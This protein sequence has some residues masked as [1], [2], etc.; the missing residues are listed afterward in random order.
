MGTAGK[1]GKGLLTDLLRAVLRAS[2][3]EL[4]KRAGKI[5]TEQEKRKSVQIGEIKASAE[6]ISKEYD[7]NIIDSNLH[8]AGSYL[9]AIIPVAAG[10]FIA[11]VTLPVLAGAGTFAFVGTGASTTVYMIS[12]GA[13]I[14]GGTYKVVD[15]IMKVDSD[16]NS[17]KDNSHSNSSKGAEENSDE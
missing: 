6:L 2:G 15:N 9:K 16:I 12:N 1:I 14:A 8:N 3:T 13:V 4:G 5:G 7:W 10:T 11:Y 17:R